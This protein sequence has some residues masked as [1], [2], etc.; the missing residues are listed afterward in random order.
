MCGSLPRLHPTEKCA[1]PHAVTNRSLPSATGVASSGAGAGI[2]IERV[3]RHDC[4]SNR[5]ARPPRLAR[6]RSLPTRENP[7]HF[8][9]LRLEGGV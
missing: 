6:V 9:Q 1:L 5:N 2:R 7:R 4:D 8:R 3:L